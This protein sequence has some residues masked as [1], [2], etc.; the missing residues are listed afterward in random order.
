MP[1]LHRF[2]ACGEVAQEIRCIRES[3]TADRFTAAVDSSEC[4]NNIIHVTLGVR[5]AR[6]GESQ[7]FQ[8]GVEYS[9]LRPSGLRGSP[10]FALGANLF[11]ELDFGGRLRGYHS[12]ITRTFFIGEAPARFREVYD[13][14]RA[15]QEAG[16]AAVRPGVPAE[17][18]DDAA[19]RVIA[20]AG[21][22][23]YFMHR[24]GHGIGL[25]EHEAPY[26]VAGNGRRLEAGMAFSVEPG[27]YLPG[28][29]GVRL[30]DVVVVTPGGVERLNDAP[31]DLHV[32]V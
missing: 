25:E 1:G 23:P 3:V 32:A 27:I 11:E 9:D 7:E 26:I 16:V 14:V 20:A 12:D 30:E 31:H 2:E 18:V 8:L 13:V 15:A 24:T 10:F 21:Y 22:G 28:E 5:A 6:D 4:L 17:E 19:R 29:F